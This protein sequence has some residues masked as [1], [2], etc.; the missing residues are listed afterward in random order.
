MS[1]DR[2]Q[3]ESISTVFPSNPETFGLSRISSTHSHHRNPIS[4]QENS[5]QED[6]TQPQEP[7][8]QPEQLPE[9]LI[10]NTGDQTPSAGVAPSAV[11]ASSAA[12]TQNCSCSDK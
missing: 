10:A 1:Q 6:L 4:E 3:A 7:T 9:V 8:E 11:I 2:T 5:D 12:I